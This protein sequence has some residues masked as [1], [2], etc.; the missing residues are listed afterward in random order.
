MALDQLYVRGIE[1]RNAHVCDRPRTPLPKDFWTAV[2]N[3][4]QETFYKYLAR[5][6]DCALQRFKTD[7]NAQ[8][9]TAPPA[10]KAEAKDKEKDK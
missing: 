2:R 7:P 5:S 4:R 8:K 9:Q 1:G 3:M 10:P 6:G